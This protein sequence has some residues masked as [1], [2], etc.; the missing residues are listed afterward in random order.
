MYLAYQTY[1][2]CRNLLKSGLLTLLSVF[3][4]LFLGA[5]ATVPKPDSA[6]SEVGVVDSVIEPNQDQLI[7][8][9]E[10]SLNDLPLQELDAQ[11]LEQLLLMN[12]AS[13]DQNW[14]QA[15]Q[16]G[17][18]AAQTSEDFRLARLTT[19]MFLQARNYDM[20]AK[21]AELWTRLQEGDETAQDMQILALVGSNDTDSAIQVI[22]K[23]GEDRE[24]DAHIRQIAGLLIRQT[25]AEPAIEVVTQLTQ[26]HPE[27]AQVFT[28]SAFVA[29]HFRKFDLATQWVDK[30][31]ALRGDWDLA[32]Q[33]KSRLLQNQGKLEERAVFIE[34]FVKDNPK[35]QGMRISY[36]AELARSEDYAAAFEVMQGVIDDDPQNVDALEYAGALAEELEDRAQARK[37]F[38]QALNQEPG[39]DQIRWSLAR[40]A[41]LD[42]NL[43]AAERLFNDISS[44]ELFIRAQIQVANIRKDTQGTRIAV[45]TLR[46]LRPRTQ[47]EYIQIAL[48][49]HF[50]LTDAFEYKEALS[51]LN[52][53]MVYLPDDLQLLYAR[54][55]VA[56]ELDEIELA[57]RDLRIVISRDPQN[58][59]A[60]NALG[61][62]LADKTDRLEE[63]KEL[64]E[65]ALAILPNEAH[66]LDS[67]GWILYRLE[68]Y[69]KA[70]E[71]LER[72]LSSDNNPEIIAHLGEVLWE[73]GDQEGARE[74]WLR[75]YQ[76]DT[77]HPALKK[78]LER[79][80]VDFSTR[81]E[82]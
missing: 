74:V 58:A 77:M 34:Q 63:A 65:A 57:E 51:A 13:L 8:L 72:A 73:S 28:S 42:E 23:Q 78:T 3:F 31:I 62:T 37:L 11:L 19:M 4:A 60:L 40:L 32:A 15:G 26:D 76:E 12:L 81:P 69:P 82:A 49:R 80:G 53:T 5:C 50:F 39:N 71:F 75:G 18:L 36:A 56:A 9:T 79:Y 38:Q 24:V 54:A 52:E 47:Q 22:R 70:I 48:T 14:D 59:N 35:S 7:D 46:A 27:S 55:L 41:L 2:I 68:D 25:S 44:D 20:A 45:N 21:G 33:M 29:E 6:Q 10:E 66:I 30:A 16:N 64:V 67:M 43:V 17:F 1:F 61:Y